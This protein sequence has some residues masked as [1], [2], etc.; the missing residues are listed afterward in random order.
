MSLLEAVRELLRLSRRAHLLI[1][2]DGPGEP[3]WS[4]GFSNGA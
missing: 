4:S 1:V 3:G 2:G